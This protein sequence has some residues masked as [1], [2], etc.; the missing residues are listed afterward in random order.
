MLPIAALVLSGCSAGQVA[1]TATQERDRTG[2]T[3]RIGDITVRAAAL[4]HPPD[5]VHDPGDPVELTMVIVNGGRVDDEL[6]AVTGAPF[7]G[8]TIGAGGGGPGLSLPSDAKVFV[9]S[10]PEGPTVT[11]TG[12]AERR[13]AAH[14]VELTLT[15]ARA[16]ETT[17]RA[18]TAPAPGLQPRAPAFDFHRETGE[19]DLL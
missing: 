19:E 17:V 14:S 10:D 4:A 2:G 7:T 12:L 3:T 6:V 13:T 11:L 5:G 15:F 9:G 16:G 8:A 18:I 1:Q